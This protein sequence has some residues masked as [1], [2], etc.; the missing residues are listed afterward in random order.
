[1]F[2]QFAAAAG[3]HLTPRSV[4]SLAPP[5]PDLSCRI[6]GDP[7]YFEI[8]RMS[9]ARSADAMG[10]HLSALSK[11]IASRP[12]AADTYDDRAALR[13]A[14]SRKEMR[15]YATDGCRLGLLVW[16]D[17][18]YHPS[19]MPAA[20]ART[21]LAEMGPAGRWTEIWVFDRSLNRV[22]GLWRQSV[23]Q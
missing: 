14:I 18:V 22:L 20:W 7:I 6:D 17:G 21:I 3:L 19:G 1:V 12:P 16:V 9:H 13:D 5:K 2:R 23:R 8:T 4:R 15:T 10:R 11:G